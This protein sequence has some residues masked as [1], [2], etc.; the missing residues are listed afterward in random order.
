MMLVFLPT[1]LL[2]VGA[3]F[4]CFLVAPPDAA[5]GELVRVFYLHAPAAW[6]ALVVFTALCGTALADILRPSPR[7]AA[8]ARSLG[9]VGL[10]FGFAA[11]L[12][13]S[14][15][16]R[17]V[18]GAYWVWEPKLTST[19]LVLFLYL[20]HGFLRAAGRRRVADVYAA[21]ALPSVP[22]CY[23]SSRLAFEGLHPAEGM[24]FSLRGWMLGGALAAFAADL[25]F[26]GWLAYVAGLLYLRRGEVR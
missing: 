11:L 5:M 4:L 20:G 14:V 17:A 2:Q 3:G 8:L 21:A 7:K 13:G 26:A 9:E 12:S 23:L 15:W 19:L 25:L 16:A 22:L 24:V 18:W 10:L 1:V 6:T